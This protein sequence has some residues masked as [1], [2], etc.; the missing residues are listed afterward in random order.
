MDLTTWSPFQSAQV[1]EICAHLTHTERAGLRSQGAAYGVWVF[2]TVIAPLGL[3]R[4]VDTTAA[5]LFAMCFWVG[6]VACIPLWHTRARRLLCSTWWAREQ[7]VTPESLRL[8][9]FRK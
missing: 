9:E 1:R 5:W 8:F 3:A 7:G 4:S 6:H 2:A